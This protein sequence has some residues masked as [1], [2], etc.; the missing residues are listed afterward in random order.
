[1]KHSRIFATWS[2][3]EEDY[4]LVQGLT[5]NSV[6]NTAACY[7]WPLRSFTSSNSVGDRTTILYATSPLRAGDIGNG[8][9]IAGWALDN[10]PSD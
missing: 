8:V 2:A 4:G 10:Y 3:Q 9:S 6:V 5:W 7:L 1:M